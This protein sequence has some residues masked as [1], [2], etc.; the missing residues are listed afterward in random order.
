MKFTSILALIALS[1]HGAAGTSVAEDADVCK[2]HADCK[3]PTS[4]CCQVYYS[5]PR[6]GK[7]GS[8]LGAAVRSTSLDSSR[9]EGRNYE[10]EFTNSKEFACHAK[11]TAGTTAEP[12]I[13]TCAGRGVVCTVNADC[14]NTSSPFCC[15]V[16]TEKGFKKEKELVCHAEITA[17]TTAEPFIKSCGNTSLTTSGAASLA[18]NTAILMGGML[19]GVKKMLG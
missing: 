13:K 14:N 3:N 8:G 6:L 9:V 15:Q 12:F 1:L 17:G 11:I 10:Q 7:S 16:Y 18:P 19:V 5:I 2:E 4:A